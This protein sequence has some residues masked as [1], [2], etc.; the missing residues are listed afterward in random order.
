MVSSLKLI[1][2]EDVEDSVPSSKKKGITFHK[3]YYNKKL[4]IRG[5]GL[6][7]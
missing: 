6:T 7:G 4:F 2:K 3:I 5:R 1:Y